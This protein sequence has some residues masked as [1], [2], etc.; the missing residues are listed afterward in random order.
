MAQ[1][2]ECGIG[3][4]GFTDFKPGDTIDAYEQESIRPSLD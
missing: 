2:L 1:G 4:D 3:V